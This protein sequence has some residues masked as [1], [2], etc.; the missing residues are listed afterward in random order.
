MSENPDGTLSPK[1]SPIESR[2]GQ[3]GLHNIGNT[4]FMNSALQCLSHTYALTSYFLKERHFYEL[5]MLENL[6]YIIFYS[7]SKYAICHSIQLCFCSFLIA[8]LSFSAGY[9]SGPFYFFSI[10][11]FGLYWWTLEELSRSSCSERG[12]KSQCHTC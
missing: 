12:C 4:C 10:Q 11:V 9:Y 7:I 2:A 1:G 8:A 6:C 5:N 3:A